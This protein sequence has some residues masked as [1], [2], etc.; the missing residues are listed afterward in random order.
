MHR[1]YRA[2]VG[3]HKGLPE[4]CDSHASESTHGADFVFAGR[5]KAG[6]EDSLMAQPLYPNELQ[7]PELVLEFQGYAP[8]RFLG[9]PSYHFWMIE[10]ASGSVAGRINLRDSHAELVERYAGHIGY[11]VDEPFRGRKFA[12]RAVEMLKPLAF[13]LGLNP[14]W[15]TCDPENWASRRVCELAGGELVEQISIPETNL[16]YAAGTRE[17]CRYRVMLG[18]EYRS[19]DSAAS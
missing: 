9:E 15:I 4:S 12:L 13:R 11:H 18:E 14:L 6:C 7:S 1:F 8:H 2:C 19:L 17:K 16:M 3:T 5:E 10:P